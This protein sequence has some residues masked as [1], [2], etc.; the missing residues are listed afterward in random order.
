MHQSR[1]LAVGLAVHQDSIVV[2]DGAENH[3]P[4]VIFLGAV[5]TRPCDID[6]LIR[7]LPSKSQHLVLV[8]AAGPCGYWRSRDLTQKGHVGWVVAPSLLP[9]KAGDRVTT[10]R[11]D[12]V[13]RA[14]LLRAGHL[15][16]MDVSQVEDEAIRDLTR[17]DTPRPL[18][19]YRGL[20]PV[21]HG[22]AG[23]CD[24]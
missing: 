14:R 4:E 10:D 2:A 12:A 23:S 5:G 18:M 17:F 13:P 6:P 22:Q 19:K 11:R 1:T 15:T 20:T 24:L 8:Y 16:P 7:T 3:P 21:G 9:Q